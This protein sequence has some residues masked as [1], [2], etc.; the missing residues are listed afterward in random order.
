MVAHTPPRVVTSGLTCGH[1]RCYVP[2]EPASH[3][4]CGCEIAYTLYQKQDH[5]FNTVTPGPD[6]SMVPYVFMVRA[7]RILARRRAGR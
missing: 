1:R 3:W 4:A 2:Q 5:T 6:D 7:R